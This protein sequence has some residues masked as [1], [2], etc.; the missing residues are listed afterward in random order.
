MA[1]KGKTAGRGTARVV[2]GQAAASIR[3]TR[4][5]V[6]RIIDLQRCTCRKSAVLLEYFVSYYARDRIGGNLG[7]A[8]VR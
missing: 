4:D 5:Y 3:A 8:I 2:S 1:A 7:L 6:I